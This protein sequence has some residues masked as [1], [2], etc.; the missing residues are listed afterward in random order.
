MRLAE[1]IALLKRAADIAG[2]AIW[3]E[4]ESVTVPVKTLEQLLEEIEKRS[5]SPAE[6]SLIRTEACWLM[7]AAK[8]IQLYR[9]DANAPMIERWTRLAE[10]LRAGIAVDLENANKTLETLQ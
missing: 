10:L 6:Y 7:Q 5:G 4:A 3:P 1:D 8:Q 9:A 2:Q